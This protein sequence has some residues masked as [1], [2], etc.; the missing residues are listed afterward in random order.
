M[1][2]ARFAGRPVP[3][4]P[5]QYTL[6]GLKKCMDC[7]QIVVTFQ[8]EAGA[9]NLMRPNIRRFC[10]PYILQERLQYLAAGTAG[11]AA[12]QGAGYGAI[13]DRAAGI[14]NAYYR[15]PILVF[16]LHDRLEVMVQSH[17]GNI[18]HILDELINVSI[19]AYSANTLV[20]Q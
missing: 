19:Q 10:Y 1:T 15:C 17:H 9:G 7:G 5:L 3:A 2:V 4:E 14:V 11:T 12:P 20:A 8:C 6:G 13:T 16:Y 18:N